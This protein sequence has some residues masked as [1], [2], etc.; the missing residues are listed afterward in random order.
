MADEAGQQARDEKIAAMKA[1]VEAMKAA[2]AA[3]QTTGAGGAAAAAAKPAAA[4]NALDVPVSSLNPGG[5]PGAPPKAAALTARGTINNSVEIR[6]DATE[7]E[8]LKK[9]LG[10]LGAYQ[11]P[12]RGNAWQVDYRYYAEARRRLEAAGYK[13]AE[14]DYL[15]RPIKDWS[16][17]SRGWTRTQS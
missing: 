6:G 7:D 1:K 3:A 14:Q 15:N 17:T 4:S 2:R 16:P 9:L 11:N 8:N 13:V 10:G 5:R 12:V